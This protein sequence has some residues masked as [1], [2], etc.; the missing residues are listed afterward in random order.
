VE[1]GKWISN[2]PHIIKYIKVRYQEWLFAGGEDSGKNF[3]VDL[4]DPK[5][6][7]AFTDPSKDTHPGAQ[8]LRD[9]NKAKQKEKD[10][11]RTPKRKKG[12][13]NPC[14]CACSLVLDYF[15]LVSCCSLSC[16]SLVFPFCLQTLDCATIE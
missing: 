8:L 1:K 13:R 12:R 9:W 3:F 2:L 16:L 15:Y 5:T 7:K 6:L 11:G 14:V 4:W 10:K